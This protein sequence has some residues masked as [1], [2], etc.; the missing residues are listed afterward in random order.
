MMFFVC[1]IYRKKALGCLFLQ[2]PGTTQ[3]KC[4]EEKQLRLEE[5]VRGQKENAAWSHLFGVSGVAF[6]SFAHTKD[7]GDKGKPQKS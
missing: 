7:G 6:P 3:Q 5:E 1:G 2:L 4:Q